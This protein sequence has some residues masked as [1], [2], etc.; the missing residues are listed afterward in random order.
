MQQPT[1]AEEKRINYWC[2]YDGTSD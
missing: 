2:I 1:F